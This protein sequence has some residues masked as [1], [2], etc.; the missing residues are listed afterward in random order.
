M[1]PI[2]P[3]IGVRFAVSHYGANGH[4]SPTISVA[5]GSVAGRSYEQTSLS[6]CRVGVGVERD[7]A[8]ERDGAG[9]WWQD[10]LCGALCGRCQRLP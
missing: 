10:L 7:R 1:S 8:A 2:C 5:L 9:S 3:E 6:V 4:R